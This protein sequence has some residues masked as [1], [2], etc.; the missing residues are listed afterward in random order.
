MRLTEK[1]RR[2]PSRGGAFFIKEDKDTKGDQN[3]TCDL[4]LIYA[5]L[6]NSIHMIPVFRRMPYPRLLFN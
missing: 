2:Y 1:R 6:A 5:Y 4:M 3:N